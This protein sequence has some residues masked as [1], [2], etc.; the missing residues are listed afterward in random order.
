MQ[1]PIMSWNKKEESIRHNER[2]NQH[3]SSLNNKTRS[4]GMLSSL[5]KN[6][7]KY[8]SFE[9]R[10]ENFSSLHSFVSANKILLLYSTQKL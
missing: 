10:M 2:T 5:L 6:I 7:E 8:I 9:I 4:Y 1:Y 3:F